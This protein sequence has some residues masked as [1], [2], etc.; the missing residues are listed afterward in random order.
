MKRKHFLIIGIGILCTLTS[1]AQNDADVMRYSQLTFGGT[2]RFNSMGGSMGALGGD[3]STLSVNPGGIGV[4]RKSEFS[5]SPSLFLQN[6]MSTYRDN[7]TNDGRLNFNFGNIGIVGTFPLKNTSSGWNSLNFGFGYNRTN[8]FYNRITTSGV[9][10]TGSLLDTYVADAYGYKPKNLD[11]FSTGL[12]YDAY[13]INPLKDSTEYEH[14]I[15]NY[16]ELQTRTI[17]TKGAMGEI[18]VSF[19]GNYKDR[20]FLGATLGIVRARY[21]EE[22][23]FRESDEKDTI[24]GFKSFTYRQN[25]LSNGTGVNFKVGV[26][27][28]ATDWLRLGAA[29]HTPTKIS[30]ADSYTYSFN[31]DLENNFISKVS[32][33]EG[34]FNYTVTTPFRA[35][36]SIGF[37]INK[38]GLLNAEYEYVNYK[39]GYLSSTPNVFSDVNTF[40]RKQY[41]SAGNIRVGGEIRFD[42][43]SVRLGYALYGSPFATGIN[44]AASRSSYTGGLGYRKDSFFMDAAFVLTTY[45]DYG[46]LYDPAFNSAVVKNDYAA[47]SLVFTIGFRF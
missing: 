41:V 35:I 18:A 32:S 43:I 26:I 4:F 6:T 29:V 16:G 27:V 15:P 25:L 3:F 42:P 21:L 36:G 11:D 14:V 9:N 47:T 38:R 31:S 40:I 45:R 17:Q 24:N 13:L 7:T 37:I 19:G 28:K 44:K 8:N 23:A 20:L 5:F 2:A 22:Y 33:P 10:K 39:N 34:T 46:Y 1:N 30:M 12:A